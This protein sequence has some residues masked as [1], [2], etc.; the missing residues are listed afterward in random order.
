MK[1]RG[2]V[3]CDCFEKNKLAL[4]EEIAQLIQVDYDGSLVMLTENEEQECLFEEWK[5]DA[6]SHKNGI[7]LEAE[8]ITSENLENLQDF[9]SEITEEENFDCP[10]IYNHLLYND[11]NE[12]DNFIPIKE[13]ITLI[14]EMK[15]IQPFV[16]MK[17]DEQ[18]SNFYQQLAQLIMK[19]GELQKPLALNIKK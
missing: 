18:V 3:F 11:S 17:K 5:V 12:E 7:L 1:I 15:N 14:D 8:L 6:C 4:S 9:F 16:K 10:T 13:L 19:A 2:I